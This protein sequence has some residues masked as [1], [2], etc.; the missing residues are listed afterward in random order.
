MTFADLR[1]PFFKT[2]IFFSFLL[3]ILGISQAFARTYKP[4][5]EEDWI[6]YRNERFGF[7][8]YYPSAIYSVRTG[9][10]TDKTE[11]AAPAEAPESEEQEADATPPIAQAIGNIAIGPAKKEPVKDSTAIKQDGPI[12]ITGAIPEQTGNKTYKPETA[13]ENAQSAE[14]D[15]EAGEDNAD[16]SSLTLLSQ[17]GES[18]IVVFGALNEDGISPR[19]YRK[20]LLEEFGGYD[21]LDYQPIGKTWF[22]LSG[23][24]G[25]TIY[26]QKVMF[27]CGNRVVNVFSI[28][29]PTAEKSFYE[30]LV[31][32][33]EDNFRTGRGT[34]TPPDCR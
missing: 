27:S 29:F 12:E 2:F 25:D 17:D 10:I 26:Y 14:T 31:E 9:E 22:V 3:V 11:N 16:G 19:E 23:Y 6:T 13:D 1:N 18:K 5:A 30:R 21:K 33:M 8:L 32:I 15:G 4:K 7:R 34:D 20:I 24:R 28:N